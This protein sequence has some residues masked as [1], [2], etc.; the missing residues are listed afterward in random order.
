MIRR[1][2][3]CLCLLAVLLHLLG[4]G[5]LPSDAARS[6]ASGLGPRGEALAQVVP[7]GGAVYE[8]N[9]R[10]GT[11]RWKSAELVR[12]AERQR[13]RL[14]ALSDPHLEKPSPWGPRQLAPA[15]PRDAW[16]DTTIRGYANLTSVNRGGAI[17]LYV[18]TTQPHYD[19]EIYRM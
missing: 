2:L 11:T 18:S 8:E 7:R 6:P 14:G 1:L 4:V 3:P 12:T 16:V 9:Q 13:L 10:P 15:A 19:L 17:T 5:S